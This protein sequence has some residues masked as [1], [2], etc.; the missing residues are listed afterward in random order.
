MCQGGAVNASDPPGRND[1]RAE[2]YTDVGA[3]NVPPSRP[4]ATVIVARE[5]DDSFEVLL[6][7]RSEI[8]AFA[9]MWVFPGGRV[10]DDDAGAD[11]LERAASA[12]IREAAEEVAIRVHP[13][14]LITLSHWTPPAIA[15]KR[16]TTWF[17][18]APWAGDDVQIDHHEIV[19][20]LWIRPADAI[21][22]GLPMAP[23]THVTLDT[24]AAAGSFDG[25][26]ALIAQRGIERFVTV[27]T[28]LDDALVLLWENDAGYLTAD[29]SLD[30]ARHRMVMRDGLPHSYVRSGE[31]SRR[32]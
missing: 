12:A 24:L 8:G 3:T 11:E 6:L 17:F 22:E 15:P 29:P 10:D 20:S 21:A 16:Y 18:V 26:R 14:T 7:K 28:Q 1:G 23:P 25:V 13:D 5:V 2:M 30:G 9:G 31:G 4:A 32:A 19:K 27:P